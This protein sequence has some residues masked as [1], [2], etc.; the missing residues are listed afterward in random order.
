MGE[1]VGGGVGVD[2]Q[3]G[4]PISKEKGMGGWERGGLAGRRGRGRVDIGL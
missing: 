2:T 3:G 1:F 4:F